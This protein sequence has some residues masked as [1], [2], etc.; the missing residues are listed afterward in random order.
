MRRAARWKHWGVFLLIAPTASVAAYHLGALSATKLKQQ[1]H[2]AAPPTVN[3]LYIDP[4]SLDIGEVWETPQY[5]F[6]L[7]IENLGSLPRAISRFQTTC[8][9]LKLEPQGRTIA[10][11]DKA[12]FAAK[13]DLTRRSPHQRGL[14]RRSVMVQLNP[15]FE[16]DFAPTPG[17]EVKGTVLSRITIST[18]QLAFEDRCAHMGP[19]AWQKVRAKAHVPLK[20]LQATAPPNSAEVR[21]NPSNDNPEDY[22]ILISP[23]PALPLGPFRFEVQLRAVTLDSVAHLCSAIEVAG[24]MQPST[25]VIPRMVLLG[26]HTVPSVAEADV[27][28]QLPAKDWKIDHIETD[29]TETLVTQN[30]SESPEGVCLHISQRIGQIGDHVS[31]IRISVRKPDKQV[32][33]VPVEVRYYGQS[34]PR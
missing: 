29:T 27:T 15:V 26:E 21:V 33:I 16:G 11:G 4:Q 20:T 7:T 8:G 31:K 23:N 34:G 6:R 3:G 18:P 25:R 32:E 28:L 30:E 10:P 17:W 19:R 2:Q 9:C 12:E 5:T 14:A 13:L 22:L 24:E 1:E